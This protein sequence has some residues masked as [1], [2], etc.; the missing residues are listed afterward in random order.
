MRYYYTL[1]WIF[2]ISISLSA[3]GQGAVV[4]APTPL[5]PETSP[6][7][8]IHPSGAFQMTIPRTWS[9]FSQSF[10]D[11]A[12]ATFSSPDSSEPHITVAVVTLADMPPIADL[13]NLYQTE[14]RP[15]IGRYTE[16]E[17]QAMGD[18]SWRLIGLR[19][20]IGGIAQPINTFITVQG[21]TIGISEVILPTDNPALARITEEAVNS[22][23]INPATPLQPTTLFSTQK[24][25]TSP[26][27]LTS[28]HWWTTRTGVMFLTGMIQNATENPIGGV[29][30]FAGLQNP[31]GAVVDGESGQVLGYAIPPNGFMPFSL[32]FGDG[33]PVDALNYNMTLGGGG[34]NPIATTPQYYGES[35][36]DV[37]SQRTDTPEGTAIITG[38]ITHIGVD[39]VRDPMAIVV[40]YDMQRRVIGTGFIVAKQGVLLPQETVEFSFNITELGG[41]P[42]FHL[43]TVQALPEIP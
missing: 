16:L 26:L 39:I 31:E 7:A 35:Y 11:L 40:L 27:R 32:R 10:P 41:T 22:I 38:T 43:V 36:F 18:G 17:R 19:A 34:W 33:R 42:A 14:T 30:I 13:L 23:Q 21:Q 3:C 24:I 37:T 12:S 5:P 8:Y 4:Y 2:I 29:P 9:A 15:D 20:S 6:I 25:A 1:F 28:V